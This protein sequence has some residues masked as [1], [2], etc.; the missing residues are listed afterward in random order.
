MRHIKQI[1]EKK[2]TIFK[3]TYS[4]GERFP[5]VD[6]YTFLQSKISD[7]NEFAKWRTILYKSLTCM[8][9][10]SAYAGTSSV[11]A[12]SLNSIAHRQAMDLASTIISAISLENYKKGGALGLQFVEKK[13]NYNT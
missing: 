13:R 10:K 12:C 2:S 5:L 1:S 6:I 3:C 11:S 8:Y 4:H 7:N 9:S